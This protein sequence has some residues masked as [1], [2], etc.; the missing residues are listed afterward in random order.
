MLKLREEG[1][2]AVNYIL[3]P[4]LRYDANEF[5]QINSV[6]L[7]AR[8]SEIYNLA[9]KELS[10]LAEEMKLEIEKKS[11]KI[12]GTKFDFFFQHKYL[13]TTIKNRRFE[14]LQT[15][16]P[17]FDEMQEFEAGIY[18]IG[19]PPSIGKTSF[20]WQLLEQMA[21]KS[22][23]HTKIHCVFCSYEMSEDVLFSKSFARGVF[24]NVRADNELFEPNE[25]LTS[26][27]IRK[28]IAFVE[29]YVEDCL[30]VFEDLKNDNIDLRVLDL[31]TTPL[32]IDNLIKRL[33]KIATVLPSEDILIFGIDYLQRIPSSQQETVKQAVDYAMLEL[34]KF[35]QRTNS[36]IFL[37]SS[38]N[39]VSYR[40]E[41][42]FE[43][44]K[45]SGAIE[46]SSDVMFALQLYCL[47]EKG[48]TSTAQADFDL[49]KRKQPRSMILKCLK[50]R[51]GNDYRIY[52][53]YYSAVDIFIP[54]DE[55]DLNML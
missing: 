29:G 45:E 2:G 25:N 52:F 18:T 51:F 41:T 44:F 33:E 53:Q 23:E 54:C 3:S 50:N 22:N 40:T 16:F 39:R 14:N 34:K 36:I 13:E 47:D 11:N 26:A 31:T 15:G 37:I 27:R 1:Y 30:K 17:N 8:L 42:G 5:F 38:Y 43:A 20:L 4:N 19:A 28:G 10:A 9:E 24:K 21:R 32:E 46:Y 48:K 12:F 35:T 7:S 6:S 55:S 49:A